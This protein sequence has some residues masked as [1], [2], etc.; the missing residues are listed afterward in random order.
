MTIPVFDDHSIGCS[1]L[2]GSSTSPMHRR[3]R[4]SRPCR[5]SRAGCVLLDVL[6]PEINGLEL[7]GDLDHLGFRLPVVVITGHGDV[8][9]AVRAMRAGAVDFIEKPFDDERLIAAIEAALADFGPAGSPTERR[10]RGGRADRHAQPARATGAGRPR[11]RAAQQSDRLRSRDQR[12]HR[13]GAPRPHAGTA[14]HAS[15]RGGDTARRVGRL[16]TRQRPYGQSRRCGWC[17]RARS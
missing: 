17:Q 5:A 8:P 1:I 13:R 3:S 16:G 10:R 12:T 2:P 11:G 9:T 14:R 6:M 4:F 7:Q 15:T